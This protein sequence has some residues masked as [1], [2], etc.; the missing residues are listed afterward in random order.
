MILPTW[1][2]QL[3]SIAGVLSL[4]VTLWDRLFSSRPLVCISPNETQ[5]RDVYC[6]N[7]SAADITIRKIRCIPRGVWVAYG[8]DV[9]AIVAATIGDSFAAVLPPNEERRFPLIF[10][11][12]ELFEEDNKEVLPFLVIISWRKNSSFWLPQFPKLIFSSVRT[13]RLWT[14]AK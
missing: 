14:A 5:G 8:D 11:R 9:H 4:S 12:G 13:L 7:I 6:K 10:R 3:G 2:T 1:L